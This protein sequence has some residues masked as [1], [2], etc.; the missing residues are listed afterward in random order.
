[1]SRAVFFDV[2]GVLVHGIHHSPT[3]TR[4]WDTSLQDDFGID[5]A[6]FTEEFIFDV[7]VKKVV[8]GQM[9]VI[10]ALERHLPALGYRGSP[11]VFLDYWLKKDSVLNQELI[12]AIRQLK[13]R[14]DIRLYVATNQEHIRASWLWSQCG[15]SQIFDDMFHSARAGVRKPDPAYFDFIHRHIG[16]QNEPPLFFDDTP[17]VVEGARAHGWEAVL[18]DTNE[19]FFD[20][21]WVRQRL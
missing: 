15:L 21:P 13:A 9:S 3:R 11:M 4:R 19:Q 6:R 2:D 16:P 14:S 10:E 18:F 8:N 12:D 17:K 20:H 7:F 1:M 5:P